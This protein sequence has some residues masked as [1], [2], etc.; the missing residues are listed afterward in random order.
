MQVDT[1]TIKKQITMQ[2]VFD[3]LEAHGAEPR[4]NKENHIEA[5]TV[6]HQGHK[7]KLE[8]SDEYGFNCWTNCG[9]MDIFGL[10]ER[11]FSLSDFSDVVKKVKEIFNITGFQTGFHKNEIVNTVSNLNPMSH[12]KT[13]TIDDIE[14]KVFDRRVLDT[15]YDGFPKAWEEEGINYNAV[16]EF[17]IKQDILNQRTII[18]QFNIDGN[19]I[20]IRARNFSEKALERGFKYTPIKVAGVDYRFNTGQNLYGLSVNKKNIDK[21]KYVVVFEGEKSVLKM[22]SWYDDSTAV[23]INGSNFTEYHLALLKSLNIEKIFFAFDKEYHGNFEGR[24]YYEKIRSII[25]KS[26]GVIGDV[27]LIWDVNG[28]LEYKDAPVDQGKEVFETLKREAIKIQ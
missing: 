16:Q 14:L 10:I 6:C 8:Y 17:G 21:Y 15:F 13:K 4:W 11:I 19:L 25:Q 3:F 22:N 26:R 24:R 7:H 1:E 5:I 28:L 23:S 2:M 18:P 27:Y 12:I 20:G 9:H